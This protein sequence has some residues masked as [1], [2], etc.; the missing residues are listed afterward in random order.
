[1]VSQRAGLILAIV[2][3]TSMQKC[4]FIQASLGVEFWKQ[5]CPLSVFKALSAL[6]VCPTAASTRRHAERL[7][8]SFD[9]PQQDRTEGVEE[10]PGVSFTPS[11][12]KVICLPLYVSWCLCIK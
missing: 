3:Y 7:T 4:N 9:P 5:G 1:M 2:L 6:G 10:E 12:E 8:T 11:G